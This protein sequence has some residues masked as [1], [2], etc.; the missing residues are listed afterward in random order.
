MYNPELLFIFFSFFIAAII[1]LLSKNR[2]VIEASSIIASFVALVGSV[3]IALQVAHS[4]EYAP[5]SLFSVDA[6]GAIVMLII[7]FVGITAALYS[8]KYLQ[9]ETAEHIIG[10]SGV[11]HLHS[12]VREYFIL[13]N[14]FMATMFL[15]ITV[16]SP[17][18]AW[19][20]IE[21]TT[22][23]S[24]FLISFYNKPSATEGA[25]KYLIIN[26][27]GILLGFFGTLLYF[28]SANSFISNGLVTWHLLLANITSL[29][30]LIIK[31]A[32][33]FV[34]IGYGTKV[35]FVPMHTW[36]PDAYSKTPAPIGALFSGALLPV[37]F[38][39]IL[40]FKMIT[41]AAVGPSFSQNL[42]II[43]GLLSVAVASAI[44]FVSA[45][46]KR[47]LAYS[48]IENAGMMALGFGFGGIG[49]FAAMLHM[50]YHSFIKSALFFLSGNL[51]LKYHSTKIAMVRG[52]IN[53]IP[54]TAA[55]FLA[56]FLIVT[57]APP[58][59]I[60]FTKI[61][62]LSAGIKQYPLVVIAIIVCMTILFI[63]FLKHT[64]AM[65][66]GPAPDGIKKQQENIWLLLPPLALIILALCLSFYIPPFLR[67]L[68]NYVTMYY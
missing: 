31:V 67:T 14:L 10:S 55:L 5:F 57:G 21:A 59:G 4:G 28:S 7:A 62:I 66:F 29:D 25:W 58:F 36:K 64:T 33:I 26:S 48:S 46:Y 45:N 6:L 3:M 24:A 9:Q 54:A 13:F 34:F 65:V 11:T 42:F 8:V 40:K 53:V 19:I 12:R 2:A 63:G 30:P 39:V 32:F 52:I 23:S 18:F 43:F 38:A 47:L 20:C 51:L 15:A 61:F 49:I 44:I 68:I 16:S 1:C 60:F 22:L 50:I 27:V 56:G 17:I 41:D 37:A 35:G